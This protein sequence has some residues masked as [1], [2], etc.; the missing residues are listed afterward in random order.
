MYRIG[1]KGTTSFA[2]NDVIIKNKKWK[3]FRLSIL[4]IKNVWG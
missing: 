4:K 3:Y 1:D 2:Y